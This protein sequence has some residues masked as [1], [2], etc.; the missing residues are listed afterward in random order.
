MEWLGTSTNFVMVVIGFGVLI[1]VHEF[2]HFIAAKWAGVRVDSFAV[3]MGPVVIAFRRGI[4]IRFGSTEGEMRRRFGSEAI[5]VDPKRLQE[6]GVDETEYSLRLLPLGGFV[7]MLGQ[8]DLNASATSSDERSY[9]K[10]PIWKRMVIVSAGVICNILLAIAMFMIAFLVGV[11]FDAPV[12]GSVGPGSPAAEAGLQP[13]DRILTIDGQPATTFSDVQIA[14]AMARPGTALSI[15]VE[16]GSGAE[17]KS[18]TLAVT[19]KQNAAAGMLA[20]GVAPASSTQL[21]DEAEARPFLESAMQRAGFWDHAAREGSSSWGIPAGV[22]AATDGSPPDAAKFASAFQ[23]AQ[24]LAVEGKPVTTFESLAAAAQASGGD[25]LPTRWMVNGVGDVDVALRTTPTWQALQYTEKPANA[26]LDYELGLLGMAPLVRIG[27]VPEESGCS[28]ILREGDVVLRIADIDG[29]RQIDFRSSIAQHAGG[30]VGLRIMRGSTPVDISAPVSREGRL[31]VEIGSAWEVPL[32]ARPF[33]TVGAPPGQPTPVRSCQLMPLSRLQSLEGTPLA[34]WNDLFRA[35]KSALAAQPNVASLALIC[36]PPTPDARPEPCSVDLTASDRDA[37][38]ALSWR[39]ALGPEWFRPAEVTLNAG[40]S[41]ARA[42]A[43]GFHETHKLVLMTYLTLDRLFR[44]SV[45]VSQLRGPVGIVHIG[46]R[47]A[48]RG[49]TYLVF[50]M[51]MISVNLAVINFLPI[52]VA[53]GGLMVFL[54]YERLRGKPP[55]PAFQ[56][57]A[58]VA[59][60]IIVGMLFAVTFYYDVMRLIG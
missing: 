2:G 46:T 38:A 35:A 29:P 37:L 54:L 31:G 16:R 28:G 26:P 7:R 39:P 11:R 1:A 59:G 48:D 34:N 44:G 42:I 52:P 43:L 49:V 60:L 55:S 36:T 3:G 57:G 17:S 14:A 32:I 9:T 50:F 15:V 33:D 58:M 25:P 23:G 51:A 4:G 40:G 19:P 18:Q 30:T 8:D 27:R 56:N 20:I 45:A 12:I 53:D 47:I 21:T 5:A 6:A 41:P 24:L 13:G 22:L 10:A